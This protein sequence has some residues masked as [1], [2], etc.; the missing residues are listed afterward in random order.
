MLAFVTSLRHPLNSRDYSRVESLLMDSIHSIL[1][2]DDP[3]FGVWVVGNKRPAGLPSSVTWVEVGYPPPSRERS[4]M[5]GVPAVLIDKGTKLVV[6]LIAAMQSRPDHVMCFDADDLVSRRLASLSTAAPGAPG[7]R[8]TSGWR[9]A[10]ERKAVRRQPDFHRH[11]G[12]GLI[13]R[14]DLYAVPASLAANASQAEIAATLGARLH[15][16]FGSHL[17]LGDDLAAR[18]IELAE[19]PFSGAL[20][21]VG[22]G[23]NHSGISLGGLGRPISRRVADEFGVPATERTPVGLARAVLPSRRG[24]IERL[25]LRA[26]GE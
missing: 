2:Q 17:H 3:H 7:W 16:H 4:P 25:P 20:Y 23:E 18:G 10:S 24:I 15:R 26:R 6:G 1:R 22:T 19:V 14:S 5:T 8:V 12:T 9:W 21:R 11:C 13:V